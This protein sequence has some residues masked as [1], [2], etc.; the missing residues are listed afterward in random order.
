[1]VNATA[2]FP[3]NGNF[4]GDDKWAEWPK[5]GGRPVVHSGR[6][7]PGW[8]RFQNPERRFLAILGKCKLPLF[9]TVT[10]DR[11]RGSV[12]REA[13]GKDSE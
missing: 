10:R 1:M 2:S 6:T 9:R 11:W 12:D 8:P 5:N 4:P 7:G 13:W 3:R